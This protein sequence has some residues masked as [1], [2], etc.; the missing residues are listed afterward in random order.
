MSGKSGLEFLKAMAWV[1]AVAL[2]FAVSAAEI[3]GPY[4]ILS[5]PYHE[6]GALDLDKAGSTGADNNCG[7]IVLNSGEEMKG[8][9]EPYGYRLKAT[10]EGQDAVYLIYTLAK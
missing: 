4:P 5:V 8:S 3:R 9:V 2:S 1:S 6:D 10:V 7:Y